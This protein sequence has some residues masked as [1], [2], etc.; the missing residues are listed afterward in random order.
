MKSCRKFK[1]KDEVYSKLSQE[2]KKVLGILEEVVADL[3]RVYEQQVKDGFYPN[4]V[5]KAQLED[6]GSHN[7]SILS[8]F[9]YVYKEN[10]ELKAIPYHERYAQLLS[11]ISEKIM[12]AAKISSNTSF[13]KYLNARAQS[14]IV[15]SYREADIAWFD[16]KGSLIDF[17]IGPF[18]RYLDRV[19]FIKRAFQAHV[20]IVN[21]SM[22]NLAEEIKETLYI[23]ANMSYDRSHSTDIAKKGVTVSVER[24]PVTSGYMADVVFSGEH[25][26]SDL[27]LMQQYGSKI[28]IYSSQLKFKF[29]R[30]HYPIFKAI[31]EKKFAS[32]YSKEL[33]LKAT[34]WNILLFELGRQLHKY[35]GARE[36]LKEFYGPI[37][38]A[39]GPIS[40]IQHAKHLVV[41]GL[42][43]Q[44]EL[45]AIIIMLIVRSFSDWL[46]Y[47]HN[48]NVGVES[49]VLGYSIALNRYLDSGA[50]KESKGIS[51]P[52]FSKIFFETEALAVN[53]ADIL[54]H[55]TYERAREFVKE[56]TDLNNFERLG[57]NLEKLE[58]KL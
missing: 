39:N 9:T 14:L 16:V 17:N 41:K 19:L 3:A 21:R 31:F 51:W 49:H 5:T 55:G 22:T 28:L 56:N 30:L 32:K 53:L 35:I 27:D 50:L 15:G 13:K 1:L 40:G 25:F 43:G 58:L 24:T 12:Q 34:S 29:E 44:E 20:G 4:D 54:Q 46:V 23:S 47:K 36:R 42:I 45:E 57:K 48:H 18:E 8:P 33:L 11:P 7:P 37:D 52:N 38:E 10:G 2:D 6:A 26:P